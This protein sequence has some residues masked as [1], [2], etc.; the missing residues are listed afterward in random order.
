MAQSTL[1][2]GAAETAALSAPLKAGLAALEK[3]GDALVRRTLAWSQINSG[4]REMGGL[5]RMR[6]ALLDALREAPAKVERIVLPPTE[7]I[8][9]TGDSEPVEHGEALRLRVRHEAPVQIAL[10]GHYDTVFP[11]NHPFQT[12]RFRVDGCLHGPGVADMKGGICV[13]LAALEAFERLPEAAN[14]GYEVLLSPDEEIG[15][16]ASA[17]LLAELGARAHVGMTYE[18]ALA[19]GALVSS[20][21]GS[22]NFSIVL[23]GRAAHVG[24]AFADGKSA[25]I[26]AADAVMRL[27]ALNGQRDGV[28]INVGAIEGGGPVNIV[29]DRAVVRFNVRAPDAFAQEWARAGVSAVMDGLAVRAGVS[30]RL[31]GG[32]TRPPK[33]LNPAQERLIGWTREAGQSLGLELDFTPS[34]GVCEGNNLAAAG[35]PNIDTLGPR[36]GALHSDEEFAVAESFAERAKLSLVLL[37]G[38]ASGRWDAK[39]LRA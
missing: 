28:T 14:V 10:T 32:F 24:R 35:C 15:S 3:D 31:H 37:A 20:R 23:R 12:P 25:I 16:P 34:G 2:G 38:F 7:R 19:E 39:A 30:A 13:M 18:P 29:P 26:A 9:P 11:A 4:S 5:A 17:P 36:G 21:K 33:P 6:D 8:S 22:G 27:D 1:E